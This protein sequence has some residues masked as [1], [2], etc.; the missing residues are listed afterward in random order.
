MSNSLE[1]SKS[2]RK[3]LFI[4]I[5]KLKYCLVGTYFSLDH[6]VLILLTF[7]VLFLIRLI[8]GNGQIKTLKSFSVE[9]K[10][11]TLSFHF[12]VCLFLFCFVFCVLLL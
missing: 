9:I 3:F 2:K 12:L 11:L 1:N 7:L 10:V 8:E 6:C 4:N 5:L